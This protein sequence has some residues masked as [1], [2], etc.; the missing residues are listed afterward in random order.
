MTEE[1]LSDSVNLPTTLS[2]HLAQNVPLH[3]ALG[4]NNEISFLPI[5]RLRLMVL[6]F[7]CITI[8]GIGFH[9]DIMDGLVGRYAAG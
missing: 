4:H 8:P 7:I 2:V 9:T 5:N 3:T 6:F 1:L